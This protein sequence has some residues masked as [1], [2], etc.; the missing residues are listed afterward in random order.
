MT[1]SFLFLLNYNM[2]IYLINGM[3]TSALSLQQEVKQYPSRPKIIYN[4]SSGIPLDLFNAT[5]GLFNTQ[6]G[7]ALEEKASSKLQR[8]IIDAIKNQEKIQLIAHSQGSIIL[9]NVLEHLYRFPTFA[10]RIPHF[11]AITTIGAA[12]YI[13]P[14][15]LKLNIINNSQDY[16]AHFLY[17]LNYFL[18]NQFSNSDFEIKQAKITL[19]DKG[20]LLNDYLGSLKN[21]NK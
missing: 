11:I 12:N 21:M 4:P 7:L 18:E 6:Q 17:Y 9:K 1:K 5:A 3:N 16:L 10:K 20:H 13:W 15:N 19:N 8:V 14:K 2:K